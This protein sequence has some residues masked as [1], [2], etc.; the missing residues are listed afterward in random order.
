VLRFGFVFTNLETLRPRQKS[1][2]QSLK[3][4]LMCDIAIRT[5]EKKYNDEHGNIKSGAR[6]KKKSDFLYDFA[7]FVCLLTKRV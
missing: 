6:L 2:L 4:S 5:G 1:A 3:I 7:I